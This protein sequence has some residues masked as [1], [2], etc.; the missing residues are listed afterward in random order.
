[1]SVTVRMAVASD[2]DDMYAI[3][4]AVHLHMYDDIVPRSE[5]Q[6]LKNYY[7][8]TPEH[9]QDYTKRRLDQLRDPQ[10]SFRIAEQDGQVV[11]FKMSRDEANGDSHGCGLYVRP[12]RQGLGIGRLLLDAWLESIQPGKC[13]VLEVVETNHR[14]I[15]L[16]ERAG[17]TQ[18][19]V[20]DKTYFGAAMYRMTCKVID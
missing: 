4:R 14:A 1:M 13:A 10:W 20:T 7:K 8:D 12:D 3:S 17:F 5:H 15:A 2:I 11:G 16:Y 18:S 19:G 6:R 9:R